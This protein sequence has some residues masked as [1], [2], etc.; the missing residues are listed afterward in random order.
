MASSLMPPIDSVGS[1]MSML[2]PLTVVLALLSALSDTERVSD[3]PA[4]LPLSVTGSGQTATPEPAAPFAE[5]GSEQLKLAVTA[6]TYQPLPPSGLPGVTAAEIVG[7]VLSRWKR[8]ESV[9]W[10][11]ATS[12]ADPLIRR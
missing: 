1:S 3:W 5:A 2:I 10:F 6:W 4:P 7:L 11:P 8:N 12:S 9:P